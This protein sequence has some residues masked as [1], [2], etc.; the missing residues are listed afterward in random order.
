MSAYNRLGSGSFR[1]EE[2]G[3]GCEKPYRCAVVNGGNIDPVSI[4]V[5]IPHTWVLDEEDDYRV[6]PQRVKHYKRIGIPMT[7]CVI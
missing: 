6:K 5:I 1:S 7:V 4:P 3:G 2:M